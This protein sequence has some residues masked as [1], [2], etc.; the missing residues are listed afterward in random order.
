KEYVICRIKRTQRGK[1]SFASIA[2][3]LQPQLV[4]LVSKKP[5][6]P[7]PVPGMSP[8]HYKEHPVITVNT[9]IGKYR[10]PILMRGIHCDM[11]GFSCSSANMAPSIDRVQPQPLNSKV[12]LSLSQSSWGILQQPTLLE[13]FLCGMKVFDY[14]LKNFVLLVNEL[15]N[16][17]T[18]KE[19]NDDCNLKSVEGSSD[20][21]IRSVASTAMPSHQLDKEWSNDNNLLV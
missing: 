7:I 14:S 20:D 15:L 4:P 11:N 18:D 10:T 21:N 12:G 16:S 1:R 17:K 6:P 9:I 19:W 5:S 2:P 3:Q 8:H 13:E